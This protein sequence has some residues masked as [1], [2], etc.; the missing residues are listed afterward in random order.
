MDRVTRLLRS[1]AAAACFFYA[2]QAAAAVRCNFVAEAP[3]YRYAGHLIIDGNRSRADITEGNHPLFN[4]N[5]SILTHDNVVM[6]LDHVRRTWFRRRLPSTMRG[7]L[8]TVG[9]IGETTASGLK[10]TRSRRIVQSGEQSLE[11][12]TIHAEYALQMSVAGERLDGEVR[13]EIE[14]DVDPRIPQTA[15]RHG[16]Q[17]AARTGFPSI[18]A[19]LARR[20]P[21]RLPLRQVVSATRRIAGGPLITE[22]LTLLLSDVQ[23]IPGLSRVFTPPDGYTYEEPV[24]TFGE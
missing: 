1:G 8:A 3:G 4:P 12:H 15:F 16:L 14:L 21:A 7:P 20:I 22:T 13:M 24:F 23:T 10:I 5:I 6:V 2:T 18:D 9:G 19:A 17:Y 11:R